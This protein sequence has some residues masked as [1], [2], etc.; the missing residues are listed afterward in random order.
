MMEYIEN[1]GDV[2]K[3][4]IV[5]A[6]EKIRRE[7]IKIMLFD[8]L[9]RSSDNNLRNILV[10]KMGEVVSID[11]G[12]L[13]GKRKKVWNKNDWCLKN[14]KWREVESVVEE[15]LSLVDIER[16]KEEMKLFGFDTC[17]FDDRVRRYKE[18]VKEE[19]N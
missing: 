15:L 2:G 13:F 6:N 11:E 3:N 1:I 4:K 17:E 18:I 10:T 5:L 19:F 7:V 9:F 16:V 12:D 8:G 14:C